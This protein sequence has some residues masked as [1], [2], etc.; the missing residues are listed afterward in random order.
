[1]SFVLAM[2]GAIVFAS[3]VARRLSAESQTGARGASMPFTV[4]AT[5]AGYGSVAVGEDT[6]GELWAPLWRDGLSY[7]EIQHFVSEGRSQ[8]GRNQARTGVDFVRATATLG[9]D[10]SVDEF[11]RYLISVR[12]GQNVLAVPIGRFKVSDRVRPEADL[13]RQLDDWV[14]R[15]RSNKAPG[16]LTAALNALDRAQFAVATFGGARHLQPCLAHSPRPSRRHH[17]H[18]NFGRPSALIRSLVC[19]PESGC[20]YSTTIPPSSGSP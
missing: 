14:G 19:W 10:R 3:A 11:V 16:A 13:L 8:W 7:R 6:R 17:G 18:P 1:M 4:A 12:N 9:V 2:E 15:A 20:L 5:S